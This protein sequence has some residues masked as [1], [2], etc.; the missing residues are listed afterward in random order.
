PRALVTPEIIY[1]AQ[2]D[3]NATDAQHEFREETVAGPTV[4]EVDRLVG[5]A[6]DPAS[7]TA[8]KLGVKAQH[9]FDL[10]SVKLDRMRTV[11]ERLSADVI[12]TSSAVK[13]AADRRAWLYSLLLAAALV[14]AVV[15][16]LITARSLILPMRRLERA[17]EETAG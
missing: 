10:M 14:L 15:L 16:A 12:A 9:W 5:E 7:A 17:A 1:T 6:L 3:A 13:Q 4:K 8:P 2:F 11:E